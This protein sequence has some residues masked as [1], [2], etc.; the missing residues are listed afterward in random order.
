MPVRVVRDH[1][2]VSVLTRWN[3]KSATTSAATRGFLFFVVNLH[4]GFRAASAALT[5]E[6]ALR[7]VTSGFYGSLTQAFSRA[8]PRWA[9]T[10]AASIVLPVLSHSV[11]LLVH[12]LRGTDQ[13]ALSITSSV[14]FTMVSTTFHLQVM[15]R[16]LL[17]VGPGSQPLSAD[18]RAMA[19]LLLGCLGLRTHTEAPS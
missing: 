15:R 7:L 13:L 8:E 18:F 17:T 16:G 2:I 12:W 4:G 9:A 3:W 11:E 19:T 10:L 5:T 14:L 1:R 6:L